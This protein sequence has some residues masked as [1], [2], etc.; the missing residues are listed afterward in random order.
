MCW[1]TENLNYRTG[2]L[3]LVLVEGEEDDCAIVVELLVPEQRDQPKVEPV[4]D[5]VD[6]GIVALM[7]VSDVKLGGEWPLHVRRLQG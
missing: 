4:T 1:K 3:T 2:R 6:G 5:K 7:A